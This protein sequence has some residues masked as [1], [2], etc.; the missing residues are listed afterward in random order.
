MKK[1]T[2]IVMTLLLVSG[3]AMA[4]P[5]VTLDE[6][7][8]VYNAINEDAEAL[9]GTL[10]IFV[11]D[12]PGYDE[13][14]LELAMAGD[15]IPDSYELALFAMALCEGGDEAEALLAQYNANKGVYNGIFSAINSTIPILL[16]DDDRDPL[17]E[18]VAELAAILTAHPELEALIDGEAGAGTYDGIIED[19]TDLADDIAG[20]LDDV[21]PYSSMI[22][23]VIELL[24]DMGD[25]AAALAGLSTEMQTT[26]TDLL[27]QYTGDIDN[28]IDQVVAVQAAFAAV[29]G[30]GLLTTE[31]AA[32][33]TSMSN[34]VTAVLGYVNGILDAVNN[35]QVYGV[36]KAGDEPFSGAGDYDGDGNTNLVAFTGSDGSKAGFVAAASGVNPYYAGNTNLPAVG[37]AGLAAIAGLMSLGGALSLRK[38]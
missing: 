24:Q 21:A 30:T 11:Q 27:D 4:L 10:A 26:V 25:F 7:C 16:G 33:V 36:A 31:E 32:A 14:D 22:P 28:T 20:I 37:L 1:L 38:K 12:L 6:A 3:G 13:A 19:L 2:A 8:A 35:L 17:N 23:D 15:G 5:K 18:R 34:D 29:L 9:L